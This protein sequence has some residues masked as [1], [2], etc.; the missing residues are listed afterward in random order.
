MPTTPHHLNTKSLF[1]ALPYTQYTMFGYHEKI[2]RHNKRQKTQ[3]EETGA[4]GMLKLPE[5]EF[6]ITIIHMLRA[7]LNKAGSVQEQ[8]DNVSKTEIL[9]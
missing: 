8:M 6:Q 4:A 3:F 5:Q 9:K 2:T 1:I 7:T